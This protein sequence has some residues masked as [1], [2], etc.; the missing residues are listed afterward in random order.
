MAV[1]L[2]IE[3]IESVILIQDQGSQNPSMEEKEA[4]DVFH[5]TEELLTI[6]GC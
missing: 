6:D 5:L 3:L 4:H 2:Y 1:L